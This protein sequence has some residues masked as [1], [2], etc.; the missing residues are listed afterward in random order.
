[1][2]LDV[3]ACSLHLL[4]RLILFKVTHGGWLAFKEAH[5]SMDEISQRTSKQLDIFINVFT[6]CTVQVSILSMNV[7]Y[8]LLNI[9]YLMQIFHS[10]GQHILSNFSKSQNLLI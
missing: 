8:L 9:V 6:F 2:I 4:F 1:M 10:W 5:S 7:H 3:G